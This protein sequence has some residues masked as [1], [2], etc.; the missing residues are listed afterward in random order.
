MNFIK[1]IINKIRFKR[2]KDLIVKLKKSKEEIEL[3]R[4]K[5]K[6][7]I[8]QLELEQL[9]QG[10]D[11]K[12]QMKKEVEEQL[13]AE[14]IRDRKKRE[15][16]ELRKQKRKLEY[17]EGI[18]NLLPIS[19]SKPEVKIIER[20]NCDICNADLKPIGAKFHCKYCNGFFCSKH[21]LP[22]DHNCKNPK[23]LHKWAGHISYGRG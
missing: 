6:E 3:E 7:K 20:Y 14:V 13:R 4:I 21:R 2:D 8:K 17:Q 22:E 5:Q 9:K 12:A 18:N 15:E 16:K 10:E 23:N 11:H 1:K 19:E